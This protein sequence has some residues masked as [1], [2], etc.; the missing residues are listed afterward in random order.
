MSNTTFTAANGQMAVSDGVTTAAINTSA[1]SISNSTFST[2]GNSSGFYCGTNVEVTTT[3]IKINPLPVSNLPLAS[4]G[5][6][7]IATVND[8]SSPSYG[9]PVTGGAGAFALVI[10]NGSVWVVH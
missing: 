3:Y 8:A 9:S 1:I 10:S 2:V 6:G 4:I 7:L 5:A